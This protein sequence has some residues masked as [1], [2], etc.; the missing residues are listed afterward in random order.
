VLNPK[1]RGGATGWTG[2][3]GL[4][5]GLNAIYFGTGGWQWRRLGRVGAH[6][7][8]RPIGARIR[9]RLL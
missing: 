5:P 3:I 9:F 6:H 2:P 4:R 8:R 1:K 7:R